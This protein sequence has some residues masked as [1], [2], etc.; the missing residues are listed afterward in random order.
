LPK[1]ERGIFSMAN[2]K[3]LYN[4]ILLLERFIDV[5]AVPAHKIG[6]EK[7]LVAFSL[8]LEGLHSFF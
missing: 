3:T 4:N 5:F 2:V 8:L 1:Q 6:G 7:L